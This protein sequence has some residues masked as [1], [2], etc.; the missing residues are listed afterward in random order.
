MSKNILVCAS[1]KSIHVEQQCRGRSYGSRI[2]LRLQ[3]HQ[4]DKAV[5]APQHWFYYH[6][7]SFLLS[8]GHASLAVLFFLF[9]PSPGDHKGW[10]KEAPREPPGYKPTA[11]EWSIYGLSITH[12]PTQQ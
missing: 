11:K 7:F 8:F 10:S 5:P 6:S 4:I 3:L 12:P 2:T 9:T 1:L